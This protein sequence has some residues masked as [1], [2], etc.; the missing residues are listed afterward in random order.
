MLGA[1][2]A[3][4]LIVE[5]DG[6]LGEAVDGQLAR[7]AV[8]LDDDLRVHALLDVRLALAQELTRQEHDAGRAVA[9][10]RIL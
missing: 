1:T 10:L 7:G 2:C 5:V 9:H 8:G 6:E 4:H 3:A